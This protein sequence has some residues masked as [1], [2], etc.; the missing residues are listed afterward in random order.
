MIIAQIYYQTGATLAMVALLL[1][2][3]FLAGSIYFPR[4]MAPVLPALRILRN[5][6]ALASVGLIAA[7]FILRWSF[8][9]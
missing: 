6:T 4:R 8:A 5:V 2:C 9:R 3:V 1:A 7:A